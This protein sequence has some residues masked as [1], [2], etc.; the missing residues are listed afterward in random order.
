MGIIHL[1]CGFFSEDPPSGTMPIPK[2][3]FL[4]DN[5][6]ET[7]VIIKFLAPTLALVAFQSFA[8]STI[9]AV[10]ISDND[11]QLNVG[12]ALQ[13]RAEVDKAKDD[14]GNPYD[15]DNGSANSKSSTADFYL[16]RARLIFRGTYKESYGFNVTLRADGVGHPANDSKTPGISGTAA[17][18]PN[19]TTSSTGSVL[20]QQGYI[21][22]K[23]NSDAVTQ[24]AQIGLD[25][26]FHNRQT[27]VV[28]SSEMLFPNY[29]AT[30]QLLNN[31]AVGLAY[32]LNSD[33]VTFGVDIQNNASHQGSTANTIAAPNHSE[34]LFYSGR[35]E[36]TGP[37]IWRIPRDTDSFVGKPG[38]GLRLGVDIADN[39]DARTGGAP[40]LGT[41]ANPAPNNSQS[42]RDYGVDLLGHW[43]GLTVLFAS[44]WDLVSNHADAGVSI[45]D[46]RKQAF[47]AQAGYAVP[48]NG[49]AIEPA[50]RFERM[51]YKDPAGTP[52]GVNNLDDYG[53]SGK[54]YDIG[55]NFYWSGNNFKTQLE[56]SNWSSLYPGAVPAGVKAKASIYRLQ[57]QLVF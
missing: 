25:Y 30:A 35:I 32:R 14:L 3:R 5:S 29:D 46:S 54:Q 52:Y 31:R 6:G 17:G 55:L 11:L 57:Q 37:G 44:R 15:I 27:N 33:F 2:H 40:A 42:T 53:N 50:V 45:P 48:F 38:T 19:A 26:A 41:D 47:V 10:T 21:Y 16:R 56:Y 7:A 1:H 34:G 39:V 18:T 28:P 24:Q 12:V 20:I 9:Q 13:G 22:R 51:D 23:F 49:W 43:D 4:N 8:S 36:L